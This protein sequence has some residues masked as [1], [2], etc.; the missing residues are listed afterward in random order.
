MSVSGLG[1]FALGQAVP[2]REH[3]VCVSIPTIS[4]LVGYEKKDHRTMSQINSGYPRF[5][6]HRLIRQLIQVEEKKT[7]I[8]E[9]KSF[10]FANKEHCQAGLS[11][12]SI[13]E[14]EILEREEYF[15]LRLPHGSTHAK[16]ISS[17]V[18][19]TGGTLSSRHAENI[20]VNSGQFLR[21]ESIQLMDNPSHFAQK[22]IA[23]VHGEGVSREKV[24]ISSSGANAFYSL[25]HNAYHHFHEKGKTIW[26]RLGWLYLDTIK[27]MEMVSNNKNEIIT[28]TDLQNPSE[29]ESIFSRY[30][31]QIAG[32]VTEF[33]TNPLL[34]SCNL[35]K[36]RELCNQAN[37]L[38]IV[39]PTMAS[40]KNAKVAHLSDVLVNSLTKYA[41]W[42][43]DVMIGSLVF[44]D[45]SELGQELFES[46]KNLICPPFN[47][48]LLR[49]C[50]QLPN[51]A[52]FVERTNQTLFRVVDFLNSHP[53]IQKVYWAYQDDFFKTF[54]KM[55]GDGK[56]GCV[57]SFEVKGNFESFYNQLRMLKSPSFGTEFSLCCPYVYLAHYDLIQ[58][59]KG[60]KTLK[61]AGISPSLCRLS[62][63]KEEPEE[64]IECL[65]EA[66]QA[67]DY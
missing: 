13:E 17:F 46:T 63:G 16:N 62:V 28:L 51:Y 49:L 24:L 65:R 21:K 36:V 35:E 30:G 38:L 22:V 8:N 52:S 26:V 48:D 10:L 61:E 7:G 53:L 23:Q 19:H 25:F 57:V 39:D 5:V 18:Q 43:G 12:F 2:N 32:V 14:F 31:R 27:T 58:S 60:L 33:P 34:Q 67:M 50:E 45:H 42:A 3:A 15:C 37:A 66:L 20:L 59:T 44:P 55:A 54:Q 1:E 40:P 9:R 29:L 4:H 47:R 41:S 6:E 56:A 11:R 64:I